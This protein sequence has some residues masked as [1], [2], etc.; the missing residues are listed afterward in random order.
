VRVAAALALV[1]IVGGGSAA[2]SGDD[3][4]YDPFPIP[5]ATDAGV[6][7]VGLRSTDLDPTGAARTAVVDTASPVTLFDV[8]K[9]GT[10]LRTVSVDLLGA[11]AGVPRARFA[12]VRALLGAAGT[13]GEDA[14]L[15]IGGVLGGDVLAEHALRVDVTGGALRI[16]PD[17]AGDD[18]A[19]AD[20]CLGSFSTPLAGGGQ[21]RLGQDSV[22]FPA[23][24]VVLSVCLEP[25]PASATTVGG[26]DTLLL[27]ATAVRPL[28]LSRSTY[29]HLTGASDADVDAL[30]AATIHLAGDGRQDGVAGRR[31]TV[32]G[33]ALADRGKHSDDNPARGACLELFASRLMTALP[34]GGGAKTFCTPDMLVAHGS[35]PPTC[36]C[37]NGASSCSVGPSL[38]TTRDLDAI[39]IDDADPL[40]QGLRDELRPGLGDIG[41]LLGV[42]ALQGTVLDLD[43]RHG[44]TIARCSAADP[45]CVRR[46]ALANCHGD[47]IPARFTALQHCL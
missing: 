4:I 25:P 15:A 6:L 37:T 9:P 2:C 42:Q 34:P 33:L 40:L 39:V 5:V 22:K 29:R 23:T 45:T 38:E 3:T 7:V 28:V 32:H 17:V 10:S 11:G 8:G 20:A 47:D 24:R 13:V 21:L 18:C 44:R 14:P 41:G 30:P 46:P 1:A 43:Y 19:L 36:P 26:T 31:A 35:A 16:T 12:G 27:V